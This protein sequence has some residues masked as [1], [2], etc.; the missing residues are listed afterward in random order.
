MEASPIPVRRKGGSEMFSLSFSLP[1]WEVWLLAILFVVSLF[2]LVAWLWFPRDLLST[3]RND[4]DPSLPLDP[5]KLRALLMDA[6]LAHHEYERIHGVDPDWQTWYARYMISQLTPRSFVERCQ[7]CKLSP[8]LP[9]PSISPV[10]DATGDDRMSYLTWNPASALH[11]LNDDLRT[12][13][14]DSDRAP[15]PRQWFST[16][17]ISQPLCVISALS[18]FLTSEG[19]TPYLDP[20]TFPPN[21]AETM[22]RAFPANALTQHDAAFVALASHD[23]RTGLPL[24]DSIRAYILLH[25]TAHAT[26]D[27]RNPRYLYQAATPAEALAELAVYLTFSH[28]K[29]P[30]KI[31]TAYLSGFM[32]PGVVTSDD[33]KAILWTQQA[34]KVSFE[35][36]AAIMEGCRSVTSL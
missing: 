4:P 3:L 23:G 34:E 14:R 19:Y 32:Q 27:R 11:T 7:S 1:P 20:L 5:V 24:S 26:L 16:F 28:L 18:S 2:S 29:W 25:E 13:Y 35:L 36:Y 21:V 12:I 31:P 15:D 33:P 22:A 8:P 17:Q 10:P 9:P 6:S 30:T